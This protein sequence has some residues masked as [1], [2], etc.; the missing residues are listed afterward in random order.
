MFPESDLLPLSALQH[1]LFCE[2]QCALIHIERAWVENQF[3]A[4]GRVLHRKAH[5]GKPETRD[6]VRVTRGLPVRSL[7][8]GLSGQCDVVTWKRPAGAAH[9][10]ARQ[11]LARLIQGGASLAGWEIVPIEYKRGKPKENDCDRVQLAAQAMCLE[12]MLGVQI[13]AGQLFYGRERR[14][15]DVAVDEPLRQQVIVAAERLHA[16]FASGVTPKALRE[17]KCD[18]CSL[19]PVCLPDAI[20]RSRSV[21]AFFEKELVRSA[22]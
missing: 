15:R 20:S 21:R 2:R 18:S 4:E 1:L 7:R 9:S 14:R 11:S 19:L 12:E 22:E 5:D 13:P 16:I 3:T 6:G 8:L 10:L 17:K